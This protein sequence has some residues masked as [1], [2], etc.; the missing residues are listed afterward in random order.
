MV[1]EDA[2]VESAVAVAQCEKRRRPSGLN[3]DGVQRERGLDRDGGVLI[4]RG[5]VVVIDVGW[6]WSGE[7]VFVQEVGQELHGLLWRENAADWEGCG[8]GQVVSSV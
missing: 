3:A 1:W 6:V 2:G 5:L 4:P 7:L 8:M